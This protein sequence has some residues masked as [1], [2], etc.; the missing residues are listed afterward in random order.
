MLVLVLIV[1][2]VCAEK[3]VG[4]A[5]PVGAAGVEW[6]VVAAAGA[7]STFGCVALL[8]V[9]SNAADSLAA[10]SIAGTLHPHRQLHGWCG[11]VIP[12]GFSAL[13]DI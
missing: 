7:G 12:A 2:G 8:E 10:L 5:K 3:P 13:Y 11:T 6:L 4:P 1:V 9:D